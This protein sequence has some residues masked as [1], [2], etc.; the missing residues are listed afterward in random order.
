MLPGPS[1]SCV[2]PNLQSSGFMQAF[3]QQF[4]IPNAPLT[5]DAVMTRQVPTPA[6]DGAESAAVFWG[7][8]QE[9]GAKTQAVQGGTVC[10]M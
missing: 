1:M 5:V 2:T 8:F 6:S 10:Q 4:G 7:G 3:I 9:W